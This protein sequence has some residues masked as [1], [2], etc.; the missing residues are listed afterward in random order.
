VSELR[1]LVVSTLHDVRRLAVELRPAAL[2]DFGLVPAI[3]RLVETVA[4]QSG[5]DFDLQSQL[6]DER[7]PTDAETALYRI[8]QEALTNIL[9]H[10]DARHVTV[11]MSQTN[12]VARLSVQDDGRGFDPGDVGGGGVGLIG[13]RERMALVGGRLTIESTE[14]A[15]TMLTAE[16]PLQ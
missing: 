6:A 14:G 3:E 2:D 16:V 8:A 9:K 5:L 10:A 1:E 13:M 15:G 4:E 12:R 11:L 7:L